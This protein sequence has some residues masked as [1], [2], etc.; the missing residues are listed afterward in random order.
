MKTGVNCTIHFIIELFSPDFT[1]TKRHLM[2]PNAVHFMLNARGCRNES[3][4]PVN[5]ET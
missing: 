1:C 4:S 5:G 3:N 2:V